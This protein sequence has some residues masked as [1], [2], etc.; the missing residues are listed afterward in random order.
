MINNN[1][2]II[3]CEDKNEASQKALKL[4]LDDVDEHTLL[5]L[6]GGTSPDLLYQLI[7]QGNTLKPGAVAMIDERFGAPMHG[8]SNEKMIARTGLPEYLNIKEIPFYRILTEGNMEDMVEQYKRT[9]KD[10]FEKFPKKVAI[11]GIGSDGHTAGIKPGLD[12]DHTKFVAA[13]YDTGAFDKRI[14]LTFE[15]LKQINEFVILA[16]GEGKRWVFESMFEEGDQNELPAV[17]YNQVSAKVTVY[18]DLKL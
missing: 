13:Y 2:K 15:G 8:N 7:V 11:M 1:S 10:L 5:L 9:I 16:F 17:F 6:S 4:L 12:Y 14:T 18:T 3:C